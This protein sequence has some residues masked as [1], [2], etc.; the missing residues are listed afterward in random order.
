M[1]HYG[2]YKTVPLALL[3]LAAG[4][5]AADERPADVTVPFVESGVTVDGALDERAWQ[6]AAVLDGFVQTR[7]GDNTAPSRTTVVLL[8]YDAAALYVGVRAADHPGS[9]RATLAR[10]DDLLADDHVRVFLDTF[11]D[12]RRAYLLAF[13]PLGVQQDG[14]WTEGAD[15]DYS[16]DVVM[17]SKGRVTASG[18][19]IEVRSLSDRCATRRMGAPGASR[20]SATSSTPTTRR[21]PGARWSGA[22]P[23][24]WPRR[25]RWRG[26]RGSLRGV[27][28]S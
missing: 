21:T 16:F 7:P 11:H 18:Y 26:S 13:N 9:V 14:I 12:R 27:P 3:A 5:A 24:S 8:A 25:G 1:S 22:R 10:R 20:C 15:P 2:G 19:E 28:S 6:G 4:P 23:A 17:E